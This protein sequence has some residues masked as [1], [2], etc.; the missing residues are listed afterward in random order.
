M[1]TQA[2]ALAHFDPFRVAKFGVGFDSMLDRLTS[3]FFSDSFQ[4]TQ[5]FPPYNIIKRD[6][7]HYDIE[8]AVAGFSEK[9]L[10]IEYA[11][12]TLIVKSVDQESLQD[13]DKARD[14]DFVHRGIAVR[15]FTRQFSL[16]DDVIVTGANLKNGMLS[17]SME[18]VIPEGKKKRLID[19]VSE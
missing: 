14:T 16:A 19:I 10:E 6:E 12:N 4:G 17:I 8:M 3:D 1:N 15:Q 9:E 13:S 2:S 18:K 7:V 11:D 5:N